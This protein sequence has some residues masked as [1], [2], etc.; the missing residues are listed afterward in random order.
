M[1]IF[2]DPDMKR[3]EIICY[4]IS[5]CDLA[6]LGAKVIKHNNCNNCKK[7]DCE[8]RPEWGDSVRWNCPLWE[9]GDE[10]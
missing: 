1:S 9:G 6:R 3:E 4:I 5:I 10:E 8:Y 7:K 2:D